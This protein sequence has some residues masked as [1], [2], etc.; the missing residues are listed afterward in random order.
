MTRDE[1]EKK[2][3]PPKPVF[4]LSDEGMM[5]IASLIMYENG[6]LANEFKDRFKRTFEDEK[7]NPA[8]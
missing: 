3:I 8:G 1:A 2:R 5:V 4:T 7:T 6:T